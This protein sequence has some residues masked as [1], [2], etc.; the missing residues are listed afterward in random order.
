MPHRSRKTRFVA[1]PIAMPTLPSRRSRTH[2]VLL[3]HIECHKVP[4]LPRKT[5]WAH[6]L[7]R[8]ERHGFVASPIA[9][10]TLPSR[11]SRTYSPPETHRMS[12]SARPAT[13]IDMSTSSGTSRK[14]R[15][16]GFPHWHGN[17]SA[18]MVAH[19]HTHSH[20]ET[21][22]MSQSA[23]PATQNDMSTLSDTSRKTRLCGFP[24]WHGNF[25][26]TTV[27]YT[28]SSWKT[29]NVTKCHKMPHLPRKTAWA[30]RLTRRERHG[31]VASPIA[32][33]TLPSRRSRTYSPPETHR[34]S[35]SARPATQI[36]M[37]TSS[38]TSRK[39]RLCGFPHW[40]GNFSATMVAHTHTHSHPETHRM[41]Q[42]ATPA[43]QNDMSTS[44][45]TSRKTRFCDFLHSHTNFSLT[46]VA[47]TQSSWNTLNVTKCHVCHAKRHEH[48][49]WHV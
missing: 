49:F 2:S 48:V 9:T 43:T 33:P 14:T 44:S 3:K 34:M 10:P 24:H 22:R 32:T 29:S 16:C 11:R 40:H 28:Q 21:H 41:S 15:L 12:Q 38:G 36:D 5:T 19:T 23:T 47:H 25:S 27:A 20:P 45:D 42:S 13:Q 17:F 1:S 6:L 37:S 46:T 7:T 18:T 8:R 30:H 4:G 31:F 26:L 35:Q 39:T